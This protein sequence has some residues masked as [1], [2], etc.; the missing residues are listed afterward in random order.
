[1][2]FVFLIV[3]CPFFVPPASRPAYSVPIKSIYKTLLSEI[4]A[5]GAS[6]NWCSF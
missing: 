1:V 5:K 4:V 2:A 3:N 6:P